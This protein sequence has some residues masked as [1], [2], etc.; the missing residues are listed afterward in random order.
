VKHILREEWIV[1]GIMKIKVRL[2]LISRWDFLDVWTNQLGSFNNRKSSRNVWI[3]N[4]LNPCKTG[5][6]GR[7]EWLLG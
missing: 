4:R 6:I 7:V 2:L 5:R 3:F 1:K